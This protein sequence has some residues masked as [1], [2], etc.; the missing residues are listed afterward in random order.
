[1]ALVE[2]QADLVIVVLKCNDGSLFYSRYQLLGFACGPTC[3]LR[4]WQIQIL[5]LFLK[6]LKTKHVLQDLSWRL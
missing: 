6:Q 3:Q 4:Y 2:E 5:F 1:M